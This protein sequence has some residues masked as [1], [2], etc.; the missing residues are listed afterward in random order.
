MV[1]KSLKTLRDVISNRLFDNKPYRHI[2]NIRLKQYIL[3]DGT[4]LDEFK[5]PAV[6][7]Y[8]LVRLLY[9]LNDEVGL[10][11][12]TEQHKAIIEGFFKKSGKKEDWVMYT[13]GR[14]T[15]RRI[16]YKD[17]SE[18]LATRYTKPEFWS[19]DDRCNIIPLY[20][21][22]MKHILDAPEGVVHMYLT[23]SRKILD[24]FNPVLTIGYKAPSE[25]IYSLVKETAIE[26][27]HDS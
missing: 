6:E 15:L 17:K 19:L 9:N 25:D 14:F 4:W 7:E 1:Q 8:G 22:W 21:D 23:E 11:F 18:G 13:S 26:L 24:Y 12:S 27:N 10:A 5:D 2:N 16:L 3:R 20:V